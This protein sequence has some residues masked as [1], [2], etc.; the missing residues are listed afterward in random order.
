MEYSQKT[1]FLEQ[2]FIEKFCKDNN[3]TLPVTILND[4]N[5]SATDKTGKK[6]KFAPESRDF[7]KAKLKKYSA[8][9]ARI[10]DGSTIIYEIN[11]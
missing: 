1:N 5:I 2:H 8:D 3:I 7:L 9:K 11:F 4:E 6:I 10:I